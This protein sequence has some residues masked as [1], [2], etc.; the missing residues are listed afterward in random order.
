MI[1]YKGVIV[2]LIIVFIVKEEKTM[3]EIKI[4]ITFITELL[5]SLPSDKNIYETY[6]ASKAPT[7]EATEQEVDTVNPDEETIQN[8][9]TVFSRDDNGNPLLWDYQIR[10]F[11]KHACG[12]L[13]LTGDKNQSAKIKA[14][15][16]YIDGMV[17]IKERNVPIKYTGEITTLQRSLR[18]DTAQGP[19]VGLACSEMIQPGATAEFTIMLLKDDLDKAVLEWLDY[20]TFNGLGQWRNGSY[21]R[22][23]YEILE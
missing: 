14:H 11:F 23:T 15:K 20:G 16:K 19:R 17:F 22:F 2:V 8:K 1:Y 18:A 12:I 4:K 6:V 9:V 21:G 13:K 10:G 3:K 7:P 5:G